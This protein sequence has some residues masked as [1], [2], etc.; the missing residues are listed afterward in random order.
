METSIRNVV[1]TRDGGYECWDTTL[2][3]R[4]IAKAF[5]GGL[6]NVDP[7]R[8]RGKNSV[9]GKDVVK[10]D[11]IQRWARELQEDTAIFGQLTWNFRPENSDV[12]FE[13]DRD[14]EQ[15]GILI[16]RDGSAYLPELGP[17]A[18]RYQTGGGFNFPRLQLRPQ[19]SVLGTNLAGLG[20]V[21]EQD[22]LCD[23]H[24]AR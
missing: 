2:S 5:A 11:K 10:D 9:T 17:P 22:L 3:A 6:L 12:T 7:E 4:D 18:P 1:V 21:R 24:G 15:H 8:Q 20:R 19:P 23:E 14:D 13:P 16:L